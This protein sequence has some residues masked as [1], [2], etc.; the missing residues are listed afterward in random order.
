MS[1]YVF[2]SAKRDNSEEISK[3]VKL[4]YNT[5]KP[6][7]ICVG[8][9]LVV[10]DSLGPI[11]GSELIKNLQGKAFVYGTLDSPVTAKEIP[12][13]QDEIKKLHPYSKILVIDAA[14]GN[15]EEIGYVK[16]SSV[17]IKPGLGVN[18]NL[19]IIGDV[20]VIGIVSDKND[21]NL[22]FS[23]RFSLVYKLLSDIVSGIIKAFN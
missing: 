14:V 18:K 20:S 2:N 3:A 12:V 6:V 4:L 8:S 7:I 21:K 1:I 16:I 11:V 13:I 22:N 19:P 23:T 5:D 10:G 9:D 15:K 17:G